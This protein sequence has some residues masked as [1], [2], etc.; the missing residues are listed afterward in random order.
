MRR[1]PPT[2]YRVRERRG[3]K[4]QGSK[5]L[6]ECLLD[7]CNICLGSRTT[8]LLTLDEISISR[9]MASGII[10]VAPF[11]DRRREAE[12]GRR[13][14]DE[15]RIMFHVEIWVCNRTA[16]AVMEDSCSS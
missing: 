9:Q 14:K 12:D 1:T 10:P 7:S 13:N 4:R 11:V 8:C 6:V 2:D 3:L 15:R 5:N 16:N